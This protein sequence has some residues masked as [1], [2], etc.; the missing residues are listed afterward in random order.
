MYVPVYLVHDDCVQV[1]QELSMKGLLIRIGSPLVLDPFT[2]TVYM[3]DDVGGAGKSPDTSCGMERLA[4]GHRVL[5]RMDETLVFED[6]LGLIRC[7]N[8]R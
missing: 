8:D 5:D 3:D 7:R 4:Q 2:D 1:S 6:M